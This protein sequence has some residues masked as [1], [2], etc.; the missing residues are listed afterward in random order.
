MTLVLEAPLA[1]VAEQAI[2]RAAAGS[3][4]LTSCATAAVRAHALLSQTMP[5][6]ELDEL[7]ETAGPVSCFVL[8]AF[9]FG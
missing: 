6:E 7:L 4:A 8:P 3:K 1:T 2:E 9:L 5:D